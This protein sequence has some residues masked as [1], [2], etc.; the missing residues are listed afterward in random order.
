MLF[1]DV[2]TTVCEKVANSIG[3]V[4][5]RCLYVHDRV[6]GR[7]QAVFRA[8]T[9]PCTRASYTAMYAAQYTAVYMVVYTVVYTRTRPVHSRGLCICPVHGH[10]AAVYV[11]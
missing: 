4:Y 1:T 3:F 5:G 11:P 9:P 10:Y 6:H 8:V 7:V 2:I